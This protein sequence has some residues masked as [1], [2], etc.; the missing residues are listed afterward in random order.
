MSPADVPAFGDDVL[1]HVFASLEDI[2]ENNLQDPNATTGNDNT[3]FPVTGCSDFNSS[4][5]TGPA[6]NWPPAAPNVSL[7]DM[8]CSPV[9]ASQE[10]QDALFQLPQSPE[11]H[12]QDP[13]NSLFGDLVNV[14]NPD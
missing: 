4:N 9:V 3:M 13:N 2:P 1:L 12:P 11:F 14:F 6:S 5:A 8:P 7:A 10:T